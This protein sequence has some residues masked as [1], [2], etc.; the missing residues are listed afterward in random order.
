MQEPLVPAKYEGSIARQFPQRSDDLSRTVG[1]RQEAPAFR[2][3]VFANPDP[4][5]RRDNLDRWPAVFHKF[6][7]LEAVH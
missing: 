7:Q 4:A 6:R 2:Q 5:G 1:F 3:L